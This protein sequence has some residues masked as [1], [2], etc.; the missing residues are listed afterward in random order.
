M[1]V[2]LPSGGYPCTVIRVEDRD[3]HLSALDRASIDMDVKPFSV[4]LAQRVPWSLQALHP[5]RRWC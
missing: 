2:T 5:A 1:N 3:T 4:L